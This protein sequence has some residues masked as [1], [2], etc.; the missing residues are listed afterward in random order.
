[1]YRY[2]SIKNANTFHN[3]IYIYKHYVVKKFKT[4]K[5]F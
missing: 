1:M 3:I 2:Y 4:N 5:I